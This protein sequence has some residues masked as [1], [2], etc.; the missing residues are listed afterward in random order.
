MAPHYS[1]IS[2]RVNFAKRLGAKLGIRGKGLPPTLCRKLKI[3]LFKVE[4]Q[5][6]LTQN[7]SFPKFLRTICF[8]RVYLTLKVSYPNKFPLGYPKFFK[9]RKFFRVNQLWIRRKIFRQAPQKPNFF[10]CY[11]QFDKTIITSI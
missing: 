9:V 10:L 2:Y 1:K 8:R 5:V 3:F 11:F 6:W 4:G 7:F